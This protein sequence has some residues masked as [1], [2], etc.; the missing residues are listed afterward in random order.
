MTPLSE[1]TILVPR[2]VGGITVGQHIRNMFWTAG[3]ALG[4]SLGLFLL[5]GLRAEPSGAIGIEAAQEVL[6]SEYSITVVNLLPLL[7][8]VV[9][10]LRK[11]PPS[12]PSSDP[13][14]SRESW[15]PSR[16]PPP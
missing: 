5:L 15:R 9:F 12:S 1:T 13:R 8:L 10:A 14:C 16:K 6:G 7:L 4:I 2:L 11:V 3:P